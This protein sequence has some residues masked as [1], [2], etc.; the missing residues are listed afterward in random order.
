MQHVANK[1]PC[2]GEAQG[3]VVLKEFWAFS[4]A[5]RQ[6]AVS[7]V[8]QPRIVLYYSK[9]DKS[10]YPAAVMKEIFFVP[11]D[12]CLQLSHKFHVALGHIK[13]RSLFDSIAKQLE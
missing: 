9:S 12:S 10:L 11:V 2:A 5:R 13:W 3:F 7:A 6:R 4:P 1:K 8:I